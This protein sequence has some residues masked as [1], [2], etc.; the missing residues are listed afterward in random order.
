[1]LSPGGEEEDSAPLPLVIFGV[2]NNLIVIEDG[3][4]EKRTTGRTYSLLL[5]HLKL[6]GGLNPVLLQL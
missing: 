2:G 3:I 1:M 4:R 5:K 6:N